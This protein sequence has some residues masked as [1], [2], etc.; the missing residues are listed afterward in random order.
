MVRKRHSWRELVQKILLVYVLLWKDAICKR[1]LLNLDIKYSILFVKHSP[2]VSSEKFRDIL[3]LRIFNCQPKY[4]LLFVCFL[5]LQ[6]RYL[7]G[8][9]KLLNLLIVLLLTIRS[10]CWNWVFWN[11]GH[12][13]WLMVDFLEVSS[14]LLLVVLDL[15]VLMFFIPFKLEGLEW[16]LIFPVGSI[17]IL[18]GFH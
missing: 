12:E 3:S 17:D 10:H 13:S 4:S 15:R 9:F 1:T 2:P 6:I 18:S 11:A 14:V 16:R 5:K 7:N 8:Q